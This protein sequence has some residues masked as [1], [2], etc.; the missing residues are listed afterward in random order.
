[1][2]TELFKE[3]YQNLGKKTGLIDVLD[4]FK[5]LENNPHV[6]EINAHVKQIEL[7]KKIQE[8]IQ[9][10]YK[11]NKNRICSIKNEIYSNL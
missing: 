4:A 1:M 7:K 9:E 2:I 10:F 5:F 8:E 3:I 11:K 6:A